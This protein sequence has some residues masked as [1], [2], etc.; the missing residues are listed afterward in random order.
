RDND[1]ITQELAKILNL[2]M[3]ELDAHRERITKLRD[4]NA[5]SEA[6]VQAQIKQ[7]ELAISEARIRLAERQ[8]QLGKSGKGEL[9]DRLTDELAM[10]SVDVTDLQIQYDRL[11]Q[12]LKMYD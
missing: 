2:R 3:Q 9:V 11:R 6:E 1:V 8:A 7:N 10:V 5:I 4:M 12:D